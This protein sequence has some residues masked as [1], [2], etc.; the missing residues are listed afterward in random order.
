MSSAKSGSGQTSGQ[1]SSNSSGADGAFSALMAGMQFGSQA[2]SAYAAYNM[3]K[4]QNK[5]AREDA[6]AAITLDREI[7]IRRSTEE[8]RAYTQQNLDIQ[9]RSMEAESSAN[10]QMA[11]AGVGGITVKRLLDNISRQE[12]KINS[13]AKETYQS[14][15][16][17]IDDQFTRAAQT[18]VARMQGLSPP[19]EPNYL[20]M[21]A[22]SFGPS[23]ASTNAADNFDSWWEGVFD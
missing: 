10:V 5:F 15:Q 7:L 16:K 21:A 19:S 6:L 2:G 20:A 8:A 13:R 9:R 17:N 23:M 4:L 14:R 18:M 22:G 3:Q 12:A 1:T 11:E